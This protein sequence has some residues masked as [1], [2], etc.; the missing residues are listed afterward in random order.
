M[1]ASRPAINIATFARAFD[2]GSYRRGSDYAQQAAVLEMWWEDLLDALHGH[3]RGSSD[4]PYLATA[5]FAAA[6]GRLEFQSGECTCPVGFN[7][8]HVVALVISAAKTG[9]PSPVTA[10]DAAKPA[11][12][13]SLQA[14]LGSASHL[15]D[16]KKAV[17]LAIELARPRPPVAARA[18][19]H[20]EPRFA[21]Y[22]RLLQ[23]GRTGNW[24]AGNLSWTRLDSL[25]YYGTYRAD[26][27][28]LL[29]ELYAIY[30][31]SPDLLHRYGYGGDRTMDLA[32]FESRQL[33][34]MLDEAQAIGLQLIH[35]GKLG[36]VRPYDQAR[37]FLDITAPDPACIADHAVTARRWH[38]PAGHPARLHRFRWSRRGLPRSSRDQRRG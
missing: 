15:T 6:A 38:R 14:L 25:S 32:G 4:E 13:Q 8:K 30:R 10:A 19:E 31:A 11:W 33:W 12:E 29:T 1:P 27:V 36:P 3:V 17:P 7:C 22:A 34:P 20:A 2:A 18:P 24:V 28:Q 9:L 16:T 37:F 23:P 35:A 21:L 5:Y 26:H